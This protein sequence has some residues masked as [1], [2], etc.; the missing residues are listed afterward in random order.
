[1]SNNFFVDRYTGGDGDNCLRAMQESLLYT[2]KIGC[3]LEEHL[4]L[5]LS[6]KN[7]IVDWYHI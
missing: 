5:P 4:K 6:V 3:K 7:W 2:K 1:V